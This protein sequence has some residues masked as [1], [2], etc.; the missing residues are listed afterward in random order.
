MG[1]LERL[2][3]LIRANINDLIRRAEDPEKI[4][5]QALEDMRATLREARMEVAEAMAELKKLEREQQ[6]YAEQAAAWERKAA[7][8][9]KAEREDLARE[10]LKRKQQAQALA[11]GFA[12]QVAQQQDLVRQLTTQL[13]ALE[14]KIQESEAKKAL[15]IARKKG[16]EA[17]E[18][19][20]RFESKIDAHGAVEAFEDMERRIQAME[21]KHAALSEMDKSEI[22]KELERLGSNREVEEDLARLKRELGIA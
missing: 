10:A 22:E 19:V 14:S 13:R 6:S 15:L 1:I 4:I 9:L 5:E 12:Q 3:R 8:A 16:V 18:A 20:R 7:E 11:E 2:S 17:A 21:D